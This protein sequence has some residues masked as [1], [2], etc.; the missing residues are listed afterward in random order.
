MYLEKTSLLERS[1]R[2]A[3]SANISR[4]EKSATTDLYLVRAVRPRSNNTVPFDT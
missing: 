1:K 2:H 4:D 3:C